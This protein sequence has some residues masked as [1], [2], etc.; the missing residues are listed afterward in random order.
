MC[1]SRAYGVPTCT[2][3]CMH[4][5]YDLL[6]YWDVCSQSQDTAYVLHE[7]MVIILWG[8]SFCIEYVV[9]FVMH[10]VM[11]VST[12]STEGN[13]QRIRSDVYNMLKPGAIPRE[14]LYVV[15]ATLYIEANT[16]LTQYNVIIVYQY[17][18]YNIMHSCLI[19]AAILN[20]YRRIGRGRVPCCL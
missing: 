12:I 19:T 16:R 8:K 3:V 5:S 4:V 2:R 9:S 15:S 18:N 14:L 20:N 13:N 11:T 17:Q 1:V 6:Q 10:S 7:N